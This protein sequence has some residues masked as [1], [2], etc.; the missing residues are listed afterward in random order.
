MY[1]VNCDDCSK[2][3]IEQ[4]KQELDMRVRQQEND[5][6]MGKKENKKQTALARHCCGEGYKFGFENVRTLYK[7]NNKKREFNS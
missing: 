7:E 2:S 1:Q 5:C 4:T 6:K 3:Y